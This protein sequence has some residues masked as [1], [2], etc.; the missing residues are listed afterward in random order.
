MEKYRRRK[1]SAKIAATPLKINVRKKLR[2]DTK[3]ATKLHAKIATD[4]SWNLTSDQIV[5]LMRDD[6]ILQRIVDENLDSF[7]GMCRPYIKKHCPRLYENAINKEQTT[8]EKIAQDDARMMSVCR[9]LM[10]YNIPIRIF[11]WGSNGYDTID[12]MKRDYIHIK[13]I[14]VKLT[15]NTLKHSSWVLNIHD[16]LFIAD[17]VPLL[18]THLAL[19]SI[20]T[21]IKFLVV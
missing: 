1:W 11:Y 20:S 7:K 10:I 4:A 2:R 13:K 5:E 12:D 21:I 18:E 15:K 6:G 16:Y 14:G 17:Y 8:R 3:V 9:F 19:D